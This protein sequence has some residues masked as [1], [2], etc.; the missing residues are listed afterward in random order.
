MAYYS[1]LRYPGGKG[2]IAQYFQEIIKK[3]SLCNGIYVE[4]YAGGAAVALSLLFNKHI[5]QIVIN[6]KDP[7]IYAFWHSIINRNEEF[8]KLIEKTPVNISEWK[9]Q[10]K[11]Q[12]TNDKSDLLKLGFSTFFLN[13]TNRSGII[14]AGVIGGLDQA[15]DWKINARFNKADLIERIK[16]IASYKDKIKVYNKDA[17]KLIPWINKEFP[18]S[19]IIFYFDPPYYIKGKDL[20]LNY[21][22]EKDHKKV[23]QEISKIKNH[24]WIITYDNVPKIKKLY[25]KFRMKEFNINYSAGISTKGEEIMIFSNNIG[26]VDHPPLVST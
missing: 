26:I 11:I 2:K 16:K 21:Y 15:G 3:N 8:C 25:N 19:E 9:K 7:S 22:S 13:R 4:P 14:K 6:D 18:S 10:K 5:N 12:Q 20:Y 1:P 17:I 24:K 23:S